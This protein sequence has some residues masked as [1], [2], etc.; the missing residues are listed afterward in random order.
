MKKQREERLSFTKSRC[1]VIFRDSF[2]YMRISVVV[3]LVTFFF[4]SELTQ[5][6][7]LEL[8]LRVQASPSKWLCLGGH[9]ACVFQI[10]I[11]K[12]FLKGTN[13]LMNPSC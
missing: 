11:C 7:K 3:L 9:V 10:G 13:K 2:N 1:T 5:T 4:T 8:R 6:H 12:N